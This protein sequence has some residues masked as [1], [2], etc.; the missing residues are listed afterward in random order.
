MVRR[1]FL[2]VLVCAGM[3]GIPAA[4]GGSAHARETTMTVPE[5]TGQVITGRHRGPTGERAWRL[6]VPSKYVRNAPPMM[7]VVKH[8]CTQNAEDIARGSRMDQLAEERG[9][10]VLYPEQSTVANPRLCWNWFDAAHQSRD[11]GEPSIV[12]GMVDDVMKQYP[13]DPARI[14]LVGVS[15]GAA[16]A[17]LVAVAYPEKCATLSSLSGVAWRAAT[18]VA[19]ALGVMQRGAG[20]TVPTA[21]QMVQAMGV[22]RRAMPVFVMHGVA[23]AVVSARNADETAVQWAGVHDLLGKERGAA[24]LQRGQI[25]VTVVNTYHVGLTSWSD[26]RGAPQVM[27]NRVDELGHAWSGGS[28][29]GTFTDANGPDASRLVV[30]FCEAHRVR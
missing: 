6:Y 20:E 12:A 19:A 11:A 10:L 9:F 3:P 28:T 18:N 24:P 4:R 14:H 15:A 30:D 22:H 25:H 5:Q 27:L 29:T 2:A 16:M 21:E 7:L 26:A 1:L 23:D 8:G 13:A 17:G